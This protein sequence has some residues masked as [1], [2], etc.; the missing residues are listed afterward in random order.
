MSSLCLQ[1]E[2][3][4]MKAVKTVSDMSLNFHL[5]MHVS[6]IL[7]ISSLCVSAEVFMMVTMRNAVFWDVMP[8]GSCKKRCFGGKYRFI[9]HGDKNQQARNNVSN[10]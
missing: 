8:C 3:K 6:A 7:E 9:H 5:R 10:N 1:E 2:I 4:I